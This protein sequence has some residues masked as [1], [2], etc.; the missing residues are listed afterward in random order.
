MIRNHKSKRG[1]SVKR[2]LSTLTVL[3]LFILSITAC[4]GE[5]QAE[6]PAADQSGSNP[7]GQS[8]TESIEDSAVWTLADRYPSDFT[9]LTYIVTYDIG[10]EPFC[11]TTTRSKAQTGSSKRIRESKEIDGIVYALCESKERT[12]NGDASYTYYECLTGRHRFF[13]GRESKGFY[14]EN[15]LSMEDAIALIAA[16]TS[17]GKNV[18][19]T[20]TEWNAHLRMDTCYLEIVIRPNDGG[21][22]INTLSESHQAKEQNGETIYV[23]A[24]NDDVAYTNG[25]DSIRIRQTDRVGAEHTDYHTLSECK[26]I[27]ALLGSK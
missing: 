23:N 27:L 9:T 3:L 4:T 10:E 11:L 8:A 25:V 26:A 5:K 19:L 18:H 15:Y 14:I 7:S 12:E 2:I 21:A 16:P 24:S 13:I 17:P 22:L 20:E 1:I 6:S